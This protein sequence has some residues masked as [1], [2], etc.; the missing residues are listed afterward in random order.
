MLWKSLWRLEKNVVPT[1]SFTYG[2]YYKIYNV[3][4]MPSY[5][6]KEVSVEGIHRNLLTSVW[7]RKYDVVNFVTQAT[8]YCPELESNQV[9]AQKKRDLFKLSPIFFWPFFWSRVWSKVEEERK[10]KPRLSRI[11]LAEIKN[12]WRQK[13]Y[14]L[15]FIWSWAIF[16]FSWF[17]LFPTNGLLLI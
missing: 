15:Q 13:I 8:G 17:Q 1:F 2:Q 9:P 11:S 3:I 10:L 14:F 5:R 7:R 4:F 12:S 16:F 6:S